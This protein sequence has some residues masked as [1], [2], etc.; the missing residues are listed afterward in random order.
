MSEEVPMKDGSDEDFAKRK[1]KSGQEFVITRTKAIVLVVIVI[2]LIIFVG[3]L[4]GVLSARQARKVALEERKERESAVSAT[5]KTEPTTVAPTEPTGPEPWYKVRLPQNIRP[6][7][8]DFYLDPALEKNTFQGNVHI[9]IDVTKK[10]EY[11][12]YILIHINDMN[13]TQAKVYKLASDAKP[14]TATP[15]EELALK[16]TF[17]YPKND[18]FIF[19][20]EKD[21]EVG[22]YVLYMAYKSRFSSQLNGLYISTYTNEKNEIR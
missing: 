17:E 12:S 7:H 16:K 2:V 19:E 18:F 1:N 5:D 15:G 10:S 22:Q 3:V 9:L 6:I 4:S 14:S 13:V 11:M 20:L 8:Y 21:L